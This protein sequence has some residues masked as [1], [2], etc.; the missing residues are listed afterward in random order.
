MCATL[1]WRWLTRF[2]PQQRSASIAAQ[3]VWTLDMQ[4]GIR[5]LRCWKLQNLL[6]SPHGTPYRSLDPLVRHLSLDPLRPLAPRSRWRQLGAARQLRDCCQPSRAPTGGLLPDA[7]AVALRDSTGGRR[8]RRV[9]WYCR[10]NMCS[11]SSPAPRKS[12]DQQ[13]WTHPTCCQ[14]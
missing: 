13:W 7:D 12:C 10:S 6:G 2:D 11:Q 1:A 9:Y 8:L 4:I 14:P 5:K 3:R